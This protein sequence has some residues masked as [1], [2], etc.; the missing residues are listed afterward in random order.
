MKILKQWFENDQ[1]NR[2]IKMY[3]I[4]IP[5]YYNKKLKRLFNEREAVV[6][7]CHIHIYIDTMK[8]NG[9]IPTL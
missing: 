1:F 3:K 2:P 9:I 7:E 5:A 6:S 8:N 4:L